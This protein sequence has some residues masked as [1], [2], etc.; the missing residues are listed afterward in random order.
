MN[1]TNGWDA[2]VLISFL[3][4]FVLVTWMAIRGPH[5]GGGR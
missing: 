2:L 1:P 3:A 5:N 4:S